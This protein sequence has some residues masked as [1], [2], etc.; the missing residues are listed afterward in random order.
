MDIGFENKLLKGLPEPTPISGEIL[1]QTFLYLCIRPNGNNG[2]VYQEGKSGWQ[3]IKNYAQVYRYSDI[4]RKVLSRQKVEKI[5]NDKWLVCGI[6]RDTDH[7]WRLFVHPA[8]QKFQS[9]LS[10]PISFT[11]TLDA[12]EASEICWMHVKDEKNY[13]EILDQ[14]AVQFPII[15]GA[16]YSNLNLDFQALSSWVINK[17]SHAKALNEVFSATEVQHSKPKNSLGNGKEAVLFG[18]GNYART[19]ALPYL[20]PF[21]KLA[22]VHEIDSSLLI[23]Y[24]HLQLSTNPFSDKEDKDYPV[25]LIAGFHHT[26]ANIA[27]EALE[28]GVIPV[29]EKPIATTLEDFKA[30]QKTV[31]RTNVAFFQ[32]FQKRYQVFNDYTFKDLQIRKGDPIHYKA[33]IFEIPLPIEHWYNWPAS[34]SRII[35]NG[36]HWI[37]QFLFL[38]DYASYTEFEVVRL[39]AKE[40]L[41]TIHLDNGATGVITLSDIGSNRIGMR[42]YVEL[43]VP[44]RRVTITDSMFYRSESSEKVLRKAK[45]DKLQYLRLMYQEIGRKIKNG[46]GGD[47]I[48]SLLSTELSILMEEKYQSLYG[49]A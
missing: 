38:N 2:L 28:N 33:T 30:F 47:D 22:K 31:N 10:V 4:I 34:G 12:F 7:H 36:C 8:A 43:S 44:G 42:E 17:K 40:L 16:D 41:L 6:G 48:K 25:W 11:Q 5:R 45:T 15:S 18:F 24:N 46:Q 23:G 27:I 29:I 37:D 3:K 20:K 1:I 9:H 19:I 39:N 14:I 49:K 32:C 21:V 26:H 13:P 35:S